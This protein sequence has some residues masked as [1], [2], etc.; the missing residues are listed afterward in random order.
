MNEGVR[1]RFHEQFNVWLNMLE[2]EMT[3]KVKISLPRDDKTITVEIELT[4]C[5]SSKCD[6]YNCRNLMPEKKLL[7]PRAGLV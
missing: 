7:P 6:Q 5:Y 1:E 2:E 3:T 4:G